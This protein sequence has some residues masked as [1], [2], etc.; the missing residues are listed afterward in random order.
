MHDKSN[1]KAKNTLSMMMTWV[2]YLV[3]GAGF[4]VLIT[5]AAVVLIADYQESIQLAGGGGDI[6]HRLTG[7]T[8]GH[9]SLVD[10]CA[11]E[12]ECLEGVALF[13][14]E[15]NAKNAR[16]FISFINEHPQVNTVCLNSVGG[17]AE[18]ALGMSKLIS[19]KG[20]ATCVAD[21]YKVGAKKTTVMTGGYCGSTCNM[22]LLSSEKRIRNG[23]DIQFSGHGLA[24]TKEAKFSILSLKWK[25]TVTQLKESDLFAASLKAA[26]TPDMDKHLAYL[27]LVE[28][29]GHHEKM[30][31]LSNDELIKYQIFNHSYNNLT[32]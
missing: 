28:G 4:S 8:F 25:V 14:G 3:I 23:L 9:T 18:T 26:N 29:I 30:K 7:E 16:S 11:I 31:S 10:A 17:Y 1:K 21:Y 13:N 2:V 32:Q 12:G 20:L 19:E 5:M 15:I 22:L 27:S 24:S 6:T